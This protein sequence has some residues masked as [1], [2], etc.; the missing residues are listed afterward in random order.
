M[1]C[2]SMLS[3]IYW[4]DAAAIELAITQ[5]I[6]ELLASDQAFQNARKLSDPEN[7]RVEAELAIRRAISAILSDYIEL[8]QQFTQNSSF[9]ERLTQC[10]LTRVGE[11]HD[12]R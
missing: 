5:K 9:K 1:N 8:F 2:L 10:V 11:R 4:K 7:L 12:R 3:N 6:P